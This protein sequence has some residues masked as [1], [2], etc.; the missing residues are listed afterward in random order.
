MLENLGPEVIAII[1]TLGGTVGLIIIKDLT[2]GTLKRKLNR[3]DVE[4]GALME[5]Y[6]HIEK[7]Q[8]ELTQ[9]QRAVIAGEQVLLKAINNLTQ[10]AKIPQAA[11]DYATELVAEAS[12]LVKDVAFENIDEM[13][14]QMKSNILDKFQKSQIADEIPESTVNQITEEIPDTI[15]K[16]ITTE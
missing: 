10:N 9:N 16:F 5:K 11:K 1:S 14:E 2:I 6:E 15:K 3:K 4:I 7:R 8:E 13:V 12:T